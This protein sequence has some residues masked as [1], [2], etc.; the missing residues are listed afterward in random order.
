M[1]QILLPGIVIA[2]LFFVYWVIAFPSFLYEAM[3]FHHGK[4]LGSI[5]WVFS[6]CFVSAT[7]LMTFFSL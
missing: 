1:I 4:L 5:S 2:S 6:M 3:S 7:V